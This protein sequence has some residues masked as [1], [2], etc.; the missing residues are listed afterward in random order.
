[1]ARELEHSSPPSTSSVLR[2]LACSGVERMALPCEQE[3]FHF[4]SVSLSNPCDLRDLSGPPLPPVWS[5]G[6]PWYPLAF[7]AVVWEG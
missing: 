4:F 1:M 2:G 5:G 7:L 6:N 3:P